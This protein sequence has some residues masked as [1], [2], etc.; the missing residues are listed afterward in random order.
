MSLADHKIPSK[1]EKFPSGA[2]HPSS[3]KAISATTLQ[4]ILHNHNSQ[5]LFFKP[6]FAV[7]VMC[8]ETL[9]TMIYCY[10][11]LWIFIKCIAKYLHILYWGRLGTDLSKLTGH[12]SAGTAS[13]HKLY[14]TNMNR[15][16][17]ITRTMVC[18]GSNAI[19]NGRL[20][21]LSCQN[22]WIFKVLHRVV[23]IQFH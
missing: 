6:I 5:M 3:C 15:N 19:C 4:R 21:F 17:S 13:F 16:Q 22:S 20:R 14:Y 8:W 1:T 23:N 18:A 12:F 7:F 9:G 2:K 10:T 11:F